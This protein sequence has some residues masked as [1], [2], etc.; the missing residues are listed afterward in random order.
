MKAYTEDEAK[1]LYLALEEAKEIIYI[2]WHSGK[3]HGGELWDF[4]QCSPEMRRINYPLDKY[5]HLG[6]I[7]IEP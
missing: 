5:K 1:E 4:Y 6:N 2:M 3:E 7:K